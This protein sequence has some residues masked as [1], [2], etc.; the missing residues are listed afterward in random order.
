MNTDDPRLDQAL[1][2]RLA[3]LTR[4]HDPDPAVWQGIE[5]RLAPRLRIR[6]WAVAAA[7]GGL[8]LMLAALAPMLQRAPAIDPARIAISAEARALQA[9]EPTTLPAAWTEVPASLERAWQDNQAAIAELEQA[10]ARAPGNRMLLDFLAEARLRQARLL[11]QTT[12]EDIIPTP[13]ERSI[14]T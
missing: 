6:P 13:T 2:R 7:A 14:D 11:G 3:A 12:T 1:D 10:L 9:L 8:A 5:A 4:E